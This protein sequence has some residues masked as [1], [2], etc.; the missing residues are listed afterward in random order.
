MMSHPQWKSVAASQ[1]RI[2]G[3]AS[4]ARFRASCCTTTPRGAKGLGGKPPLDDTQAQRMIAEVVSRR[5][6][7][8][9]VVGVS[10]IAGGAP[11]FIEEVLAD[12]RK[13]P[14]SPRRRR[15]SAA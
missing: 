1:R 14:R 13:C 10:A 12:A 4:A 8:T 6:L 5:A 7:P 15:R 9:D 2:E 11:L 3:S